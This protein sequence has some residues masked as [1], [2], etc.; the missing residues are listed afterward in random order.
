M[1]DTEQVKSIIHNN[2]LLS[3]A[4]KGFVCLGSPYFSLEVNAKI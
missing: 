3:E 1:F 4:V 2:F